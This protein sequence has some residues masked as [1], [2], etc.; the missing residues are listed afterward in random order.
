MSLDEPF[1]ESVCQ[2]PKECPKLGSPAVKEP[3]KK[4][5]RDPIYLH[6]FGV[7]ANE[8][9]PL[10]GRARMDGDHLLQ[11]TGLNEYPAN[12]IVSRY[13]EAWSLMIKNTRP[14]VG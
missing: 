4:P 10:C 6:W 8:A 13:W 3:T 14:D 5:S 1:A 12:D 7:A 2:C 11:C 9:C